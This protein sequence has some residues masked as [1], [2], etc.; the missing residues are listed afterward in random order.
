MAQPY[1]H[2]RY[3][4]LPFVI[5]GII[6][7]IIVM[8]LR[9]FESAK[10]QLLASAGEQLTLAAT[11][12][13]QKLDL[14]LL[15]RFRDIQ[16]MAHA[17]VFQGQ[18]T[19]AMTSYLAEIKQT[20]PLYHWIGVTDA[21]G[22]IIAT[23]DPNALGKDIDAEARF[24]VI[25]DGRDIDMREVYRPSR[26]EDRPAI[27]FTAPIRGADG[28]FRG[29]I[30]SRVELQF[31]EEVIAPTVAALQ[32]LQGTST[33][34]EYQIIS[35]DGDLLADS[36]L[37]QEQQVNLLVDGVLSAE[38]V[39]S[40]APNYV[41]EEHRRRHVAVL[42]GYAHMPP[43][44]EL[45]TL[46]W[47]VLIRVDREAVLSPI[48]SAFAKE[49]LWGGGL[50]IALVGALS[51]AVRQ[52]RG[53]WQRA[54]SAKQAL[55]E[56]H[57]V[58]QLSLDALTSHIAI[59]D[60]H[61]TI[62]CVNKAWRVFGEQNR[63]RDR[64]YTVGR[65]YLDICESS[66]GEGGKDAQRVA[67]G[68]RA[69]LR[70][71]RR[72]WSGEYTCHG[73]TEQRWFVMHITRF[74]LGQAIRLVVAH[75]NVTDIHQALLA[76]REN[77]ATTQ[78]II[79]NALDAHILMDQEGII[80]GWNARAEE[81]FGWPEAEALGRRLSD[82]IVPCNYREA[83]ERGL[84]RYLVDGSGRHI[85]RRIE[86]EAWHKEG[87]SVPVEL[88][89]TAIKRPNGFLFSAF[90][91]D[92]TERVEQQRLQTMEFRVAELLLQSESLDSISP[93]IIK[94]ICDLLGWRVG[95]LWRVDEELRILR[96]AESGQDSTGGLE[97]F[98]E[99]IRQTTFAVDADL[100]GRVWR[101]GQVE[102]ISDVTQD[103][104][105]TRS[106]SAV[107]CGLHAALVFPLQVEGKIRG[108]FEF[109]STDVRQ[110][111]QKLMDVL[112][113]LARQVELVVARTEAQQELNRSQARLSAILQIAQDA[114][115][116]VDESHQIILFNRSAE[117]VFGYTAEE[118]LGQPLTLLLPARFWEGQRNK[119]NERSSCAE[120]SERMRQSIETTGRRKGGEEFPVEAS[121]ARATV[122]GGTV[123][124][125]ILRDVSYSKHQERVLRD[126]KSMAEQA[127]A[128]KTV[129]LSRVEAFFVRLTENGAVCEWTGQAET[130]LGIPRTQALGRRFQD[131]NIEWNW[132]SICEAVEQTV[133]T[134]ETVHL[135]KVRLITEEKRQRFLKLAV[136]PF[137]ND[138][139]SD[140]VL[141][142]EDITDRLLLEHDLVQ[143]QKL[144][145]IGHLAAGIA[146]EI[147]TPIQFVGDNVRFLSES[148]IDILRVLGQ[149]RQLLAA[150]KRGACSP[151]LMHACDAA[152]DA[153]DLEYLIEEIPQAIAQSAEGIDRV[154]KIVRAMKEF[155][156]PGSEEKALV[157]L[158][159][160]IDSTVTVARNEWKYVANVHTEFDQ[161]LP[162]VPCLV[163]EFN[164]VVL[165]M[166]VNAS[167]AIADAVKGTGEKGMITIR[168]D[169]VGDFIEVR[170][171]DTGTGIPES[172]RHKI[173]DPFFTTKE[174]GKGT[175]Q[176][177]AI[178]R[179]V[180]VDK[181]GGAITV[182][183]EVGKGTTF[184]I[185]LPL[186]SPPS[187]PSKAGAIS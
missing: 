147:N 67:D 116:S 110:P 16:H 25:W 157:N 112:K 126:A 128:E 73:P 65:N 99:Q 166:I 51:W 92:V 7:I 82:M 154:A 100:P 88:A 53:E 80:V 1:Y 106:K 119:V 105:F 123:Y 183:S 68:I 163:G 120:T 8:A 167:H 11:H 33:R 36:P 12:I 21:K 139:G 173:F 136:S 165:N 180:V 135:E 48:H 28:K 186:N 179:S 74:E 174:V 97:S 37:R 78:A 77:Q 113:G 117:E 130:L 57:E 94:T 160:A 181:H 151:D 58:F 182:D 91:R 90:A 64:N 43:H 42:T 159:D 153:A 175:G 76:L 69:I 187:L 176:G 63:L 32:A 38:R 45:E 156:Y 108:V 161:S 107:A 17:A 6:V 24:K 132:G 170:I 146:H 118:A 5:P 41:E 178:A 104:N 87:R 134:L 72:V 61:G 138:A 70:G 145:S 137:C 3:K 89:I 164:Q 81:I 18:D 13:A 168:T 142:G 10:T 79:G 114:I 50:I 75:E 185:R 162:P 184:L 35:R 143:A 29:A 95:V 4:W 27:E 30:I 54:E 34:T 39:F 44:N 31:L 98:I 55:T 115:V 109:F 149:Y 49:I 148:F 150:A 111:N 62:I 52:L 131:L 169:H 141:V 122:A 171:A 129:L 96:C 152:N 15:E 40:S 84:R 103:C 2:K 26:V 9:F 177:L 19:A 155:A 59:L 23:T 66:I 140:V 83:H 56:S 47:G 86:I 46:G 158:N 172:I 127:V 144:E 101:S 124:T 125:T 20:Y 22:R 85:G 71:E 133:K 14:V 93:G 121:F 102:W 60:E